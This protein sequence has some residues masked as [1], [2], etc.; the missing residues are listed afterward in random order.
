M[1]CDPQVK[2]THVKAD[3]DITAEELLQFVD[4]TQWMDWC[5][6][7]SGCFLAQ[8]QSFGADHFENFR[9]QRRFLRPPKLWRQSL[10]GLGYIAGQLDIGAIAIIEVRRQDV[11]MDDLAL[12]LVVPQWW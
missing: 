12:A 8:Q 6:V 7:A 1:A 11:D 3:G 10:Q 2:R 9:G 5:A 4:E